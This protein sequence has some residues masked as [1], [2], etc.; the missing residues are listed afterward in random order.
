MDDSVVVWLVED[1]TAYR[2]TVAALVNTLPDF[3]CEEAF[4]AVEPLLAALANGGAP[5]IILMDVNLPGMNGVEGV[6]RAKLAAPSAQILM[7]TI[8]EDDD[9][10]FRAIQAGASGY[11]LKMAPLH[12]IIEALHTTR[13]GGAS[14][15]PQVARR[16]VAMFNSLVNPKADYGLTAR[17]RDVLAELITGRS[18]PQIAE[19][20]F[21]STHTVD[22]HLRN[23][24]GKLHVHNRTE[25]VV[26]AVRENL[27]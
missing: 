23:I 8:K 26:K 22:T 6:R 19:V 10:I 16:I 9:T 18:K 14:M 13:A 27:L 12:A 4:D 24:Y 3:N 17:E 1:N 21:V 25:A 7:L 15:T 2:D 20:L 11:L 5:D